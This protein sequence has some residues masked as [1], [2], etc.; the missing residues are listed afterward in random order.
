MTQQENQNR[1][2]IEW[3][4]QEKHNRWITAD[5]HVAEQAG[6][7][8]GALSHIRSGERKIEAE[9][10]IKIARGLNASPISALEAAGY[11]DPQ[12]SDDEMID[13]LRRLMKNWSP[14]ERA[15]FVQQAYAFD[16]DL[17]SQRARHSRGSA[18]RQDAPPGRG[19]IEQGSLL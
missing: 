9:T 3:L 5:M 4:E 6:I 13:Q 2:F 10:A 8:S 19:K 16:R 7:T 14:I 18:V 17:V 12:A 15:H 11:L 1:K